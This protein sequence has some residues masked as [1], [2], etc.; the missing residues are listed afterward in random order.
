MISGLTGHMCL[1]VHVHLL[2]LPPIG[3]AATTINTEKQPA[4]SGQTRYNF[5]KHIQLMTTEQTTWLLTTLNYTKI[6]QS[7]LISFILTEFAQNRTK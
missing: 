4:Y 1:L 5:R 6:P 3:T 7:K 2:L